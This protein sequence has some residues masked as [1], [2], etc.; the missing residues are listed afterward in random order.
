MDNIHYEL[1]EDDLKVVCTRRPF[2]THAN[3]IQELFERIGPTV[4]V[5]LLYDRHDRSQGTAFVIYE[6]ERDARD[7]VYKFDGQNA[8][9]QAIRVALV[10][11]GP[12]GGPAGGPPRSLGDRISGPPPRS[13][14]DRIEDSRDDSREPRRRR[15]RSDSPRKTGGLAPPSDVDR[16]IPG[17]ASRSPIRRRGTPRGGGRRAGERREERGGRGP[18]KPRADDDGRPMVGGRPKKTAEELDAEMA[19]YW[20]NKNNG[21]GAD[22]DTADANGANGGGTGDIDMDI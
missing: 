10:P 20:G 18:R 19:D 3:I 11:S 12:A 9:G 17:R 4:S 21:T 5:Q 13:L 22:N 16:Y 8:N 6:D 15:N 14:F 7:A 1:T 2:H